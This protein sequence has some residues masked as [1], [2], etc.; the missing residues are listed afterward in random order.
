MSYQMNS[1]AACWAANAQLDSILDDWTPCSGYLVDTSLFPEV[2]RNGKTTCQKIFQ[3]CSRPEKQ[4]WVNA[5]MTK[6]ETQYDNSTNIRIAQNGMW[7]D[8]FWS[9]SPNL[10]TLLHTAIPAGH[11]TSPLALLKCHTA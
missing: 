8:L 11:H 7:F 10:T 1:W 6:H 3:R 4:V 5:N 2:L 9:W